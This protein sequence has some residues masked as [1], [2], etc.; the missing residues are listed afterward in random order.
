[1]DCE[2]AG[3]IEE[4]RFMGL[5]CL[6]AVQPAAAAVTFRWL[7]NPHRLPRRHSTA[8]KT[9]TG[10]NM[11]SLV[12]E[13]RVDRISRLP[14][15]ILGDIISLLPTKDGA[16]TRVLSSRWRDLWCTAPLNIDLDVH[17][18]AYQLEIPVDVISRILSTHQGPGRCFSMPGHYIDRMDQPSATLDRW[19]CSPALDSL[20]E[21]KIYVGS[22]FQGGPLPPSAH[23]FSSTL[24]V[25]GFSCCSFPYG[26]NSSV[27][28]FPLLKHLCLS[29]V[30]ISEASLHALFASS[31]VM[32]SLLLS[33]LRG[34]SRL[35]IVLPSIRS[36]GVSSGFRGFQLKHLIIENAPCLERLISFG[37]VHM[38]MEISVIS[39]PRLY[40]LG[41]LSY[42]C[43]ALEFGPTVILGSHCSSLAMVV[44]SIKLCI[45]TQ[46]AGE[47]NLWCHRYLDL[48]GTLD[49]R[50]K[51][52]VLINYRG[53][54]SHVNFAKFFVLNARVLESMILESESRKLTT[55]W[56]ARQ[57][58]VLNIE[59]RASRD[60]RIDFLDLDTRHGPFASVR[61]G[62]ALGLSTA[63]P[64]LRF[65]DW[66]D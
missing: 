31:P 32:E 48:I 42:H 52:I 47:K 23:R 12:E 63:D 22:I 66:A 29:D 50:L 28:H 35:R 62:Q 27:L 17:E 6:A 19:L 5:D 60:A 38:D 64:I 25:A 57:R 13:E 45:E 18:M 43:P 21:L 58:R 8:K 30:R 53:N 15:G 4:Q 26:N 36:I 20:Q 7:P 33:D 3:G 44:P 51:E 39:A 61:T 1:M 55:A 24:R 49:I 9:V 37:G 56:I 11:R 16:R 10:A 46:K 41:G 14:D 2:E 65:L 54:K 59:N 40:A 34:C